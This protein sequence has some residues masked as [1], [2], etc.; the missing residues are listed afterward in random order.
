MKERVKRLMGTVTHPAPRA[1]KVKA[2]R[3]LTDDSCK[4]LEAAA[5]GGGR[6]DSYEEFHPV[7]ELFHLIT[8]PSPAYTLA[9]SICASWPWI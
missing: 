3:T 6:R 5:V 7:E 4:A 2:G 9:K 1:R 8:F